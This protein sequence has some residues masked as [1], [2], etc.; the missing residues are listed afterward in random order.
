MGIGQ[1]NLMKPSPSTYPGYR[2][3]AE[4]ISHAVWLYHV[5]SLSLRDVELILAERGIM[6]THEG[7]GKLLGFGRQWAKKGDAA[8]LRCHWDACL[9]SPDLDGRGA[10]SPVVCC[11][12]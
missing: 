12:H 4:V 10:M 8:D 5:F 11:C 9:L 3:P 1:A 2:F 6:V 7:I